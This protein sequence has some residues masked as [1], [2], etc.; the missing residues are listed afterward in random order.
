[1][2]FTM[3]EIKKEGICDE[4]ANRLLIS[5]KTTTNGKLFFDISLWEGLVVL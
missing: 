1:M 3:V 5:I 4:D 2:T